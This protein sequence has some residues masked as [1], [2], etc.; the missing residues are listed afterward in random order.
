MAVLRRPPA[1]TNESRCLVFGSVLFAAAALA[2]HLARPFGTLS[3][4]PY[5]SYYRDWYEKRN[6]E[7][8]MS[9]K[10][11]NGSLIFVHLK[12]CGGTTLE[13]FFNT[14]LNYSLVEVPDDPRWDMSLYITNPIVS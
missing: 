6:S 7:A 1:W 12:K 11:G 2:M 8:L 14:T 3:S 10:N 5:S 9:F 4:A 13:A